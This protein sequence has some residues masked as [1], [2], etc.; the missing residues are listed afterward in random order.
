MREKIFAIT[1]NALTAKANVEPLC[2]ETRNLTDKPINTYHLPRKSI[3]LL[4]LT[5]TRCHITFL[6]FSNSILSSIFAFLPLI[7]RAIY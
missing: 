1:S 6:R 4:I 3:K 7:S 5:L 2:I